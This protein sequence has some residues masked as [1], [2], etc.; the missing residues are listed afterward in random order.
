MKTPNQSGLIHAQEG[1]GLTV[2]VLGRTGTVYEEGTFVK[3]SLSVAENVAL[4]G[5]PPTTCQGFGFTCCSET[6]QAGQGDQSTRATDCPRSCFAQCL[7]KPAVLVFNSDPAP[8]LDNRVVNIRSGEALDFYYT[9]NDV[10]GDVFAD[11][12]TAA[13]RVA[14]PWSE[15]ILLMLTMLFGNA[16]P[17]DEVSHITLRF[18]DGETTDLSDLQ[19]TVSH[20]YT[21]TRAV[22]VYNATLQVV[23]KAG[24]TS[25][26]GRTETI[27]VQ[28]TP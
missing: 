15:R 20:A 8:N 14:L 19:G 22:C 6:Y 1:Y 17:P 10:R 2:S 25:T 13:N 16:A 21:C 3:T 18:G 11:V 12:Q 5:G 24:T 4:T 7:D 28:V 9:V 23:T 26:L 27:Q